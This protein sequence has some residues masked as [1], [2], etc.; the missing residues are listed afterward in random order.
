MSTV[1]APDDC[2]PQYVKH[3]ALL[4]SYNI[5]VVTVA[6]DNAG[7]RG[8]LYVR[9]MLKTILTKHFV[10]GLTAN[11]QEIQVKNSGQIYW[12]KIVILN[13]KPSHLLS[14]CNKHVIPS[15]TNP[16]PM[17]M[18]IPATM[19]KRLELIIIPCAKFNPLI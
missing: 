11:I 7:S 8:N 16:V 9:T 1:K 18:T 15:L 5:F 6:C 10:S 3:L 17:K 19:V 14:L 12:M 2:R 13:I 4:V